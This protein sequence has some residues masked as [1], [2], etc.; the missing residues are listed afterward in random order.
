MDGY[1]K[2]P[3]ATNWNFVKDGK[4]ANREAN[5]VMAEAAENG[6]CVCRDL[7]LYVRGEIKANSE[8]EYDFTNSHK[9][10]AIKS[11]PPYMVAITERYNE[12]I[13]EPQQCATA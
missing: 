6:K 2:C 4:P 8:L 1:L 12:I 3:V 9:I 13:L 5:K 7:G 10:L 11:V